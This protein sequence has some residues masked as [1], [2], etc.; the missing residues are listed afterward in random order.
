[1]TGCPRMLGCV[2]VGG[3]IA[4]QCDTAFLAGAQMDP[5]GAD[6]DALCA[7]AALWFF[8]ISDR[9]DVSARAVRSHDE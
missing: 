6:L 8:D 5:P 1:M 7:F 9:S 3:I 2:L 4:A